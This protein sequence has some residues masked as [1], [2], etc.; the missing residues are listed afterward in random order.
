MLEDMKADVLKDWWI[1]HPSQNEYWMETGEIPD[2]MFGIK[3]WVP[4]YKGFYEDN[5]GTNQSFFGADTCTFTPDITEEVYEFMKGSFYVPSTFQPVGTMKAALDS[6][7]QVYGDF[8][9]AM[10]TNDP[11]GID[12]HMG[13]TFLPIWKVPNAIMIADVTP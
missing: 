1:R 10:V 7:K 6:L 5:D 8:A 2:G 13:T 12:T 11:I 3:K 4:V 9:Y